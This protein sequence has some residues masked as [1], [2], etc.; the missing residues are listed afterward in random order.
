[1][2]TDVQVRGLKARSTQFKAY[3][4]DGLFLLVL[5]VGPRTPKGTKAWRFRFMRD[6][7][8]SDVSLGNYPDVS[9][10][11]A[12]NRAAE[13][14]HR[15]RSGKDPLQERKALKSTA[16]NTFQAVA[17]RFFAGRKGVK[18]VRGEFANASRLRRDV[19]PSLGAKPIGD[20]T[21]PMILEAVRRVEARGASEA[22]ARTLRAVGQVCRFALSE[23]ILPADPTASLR[24]SLKPHKAGHHAAEVDPERLAQVLR[25]LEAY[26]GSP[27]V[28]NALRL[29][30]MVFARPGEVT[31]MRWDDVD[32]QAREWRYTLSKTEQDHIV[33]LADQAVRLLEDMKLLSG[34]S[35]HVFT[36]A[37]GRG[38]PITENALGCALK[39]MGIGGR[40]DEGLRQT[41]H[42]FRASARTILDEVLNVPV[43]LIEAQLGHVVREFNGRA[44]NR[45]TH[46]PARRDMM[47]QWADYL[48]RLRDGGAVI[49]FRKG[50]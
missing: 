24:G 35:E 41:A 40:N 50:A 18:S 45:T 33:P 39:G 2:L 16:G 14:R 9:L 8:R 11:E 34:G 36:S 27:S 43:N 4:S 31:S 30:T 26:P 21:P 47:Q 20:L 3:D 32:L 46:L 19:F 29:L 48:D 17:E 15:V 38:R 42:G 23:G 7:K 12:R 5:P 25:A 37:R 1:M 22:A 10:T 44:Y 6:G 49:P 13:L 28:K